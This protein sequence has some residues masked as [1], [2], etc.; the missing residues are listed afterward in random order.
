MHQT[1]GV[2]R[3]GLAAVV[4][5][6]GLLATGCL[7]ADLGVHVDDDGSGQVELVV[8]LPTQMLD[9]LGIDEA[10]LGR[11]AESMAQAAAASAGLD[12]SSIEVS[13]VNAP[14]ERGVRAVIAFDDYRQVEPAM[15]GSGIGAPSPRPFK[16]FDIEQAPSGAW[17]FNGTVDPGG[18]DAMAAE[19]R[20]AIARTP[21]QVPD[22]GTAQ[23]D[24]TV[25]MSV[26]LPG[27]V[28]TSNST[29][30]DGGRARWVIVGDH[31]VTDLSMRTRAAPAGAVPAGVVG[32]AA[33]AVV[34][35]GGVVALTA[36]RRR[37]R[38]RSSVVPAE[39]WGPP[40]VASDAP[41]AWG[42]APIP[43]PTL[44]SPTPSPT[45]PPPFPGT[46]HEDEPS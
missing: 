3:S 13:T 46:T 12:R 36:V 32:S 16:A 24:V 30:I 39:A 22:D 42:T 17:S 5:S 35:L 37:R 25:K 11:V 27:E 21:L 41:P 18:L 1:G 23:G 9:R 10:T 6:C 15:T 38:R 34:L 20:A 31:A 14:D 8:Y 43:P 33:V 28:A 4:L 45:L 29:D 40:P 2:R 44:P 26:T 19:I 7:R